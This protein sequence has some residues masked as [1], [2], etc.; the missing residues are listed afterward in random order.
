MGD[1]GGPGLFYTS[2]FSVNIALGHDLIISAISTIFR[3]A[4]TPHAPTESSLSA[5]VR[6]PEAGIRFRSSFTP[7]T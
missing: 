2:T 5:E 7:N 1:S 3:Y 4:I 6:Q